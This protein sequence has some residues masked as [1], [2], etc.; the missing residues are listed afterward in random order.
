MK[1]HR[2]LVGDSI[3]MVDSGV[4]TFFSKFGINTASHITASDYIIDKGMSQLEDIM[5][6]A[7]EYAQFLKDTAQYWDIAIDF[8]ADGFLEESVVDEIHEDIVD[9]IGGDRSRL[10]RVYH[11]ER[12]DSRKWWKNICKDPRYNCLGIGSGNRRDREFY[13]HMTRFAHEHGKKVHALG[14]GAPSFLQSVPVDTVDTTSHLSGGKFGRVYTPI[15]LIGF[16]RDRSKDS[17]VYYD[18]L[19]TDS[20]AFLE[21]LW[22]DK[23]NISVE[24]LKSSPYVRN[25]LNI[26]H[27]NEYWDIPYT[28]K[29]EA[30]PL[31]DILGI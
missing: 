17:V 22:R 29:E 13:T 25:T 16:G 10:M 30:I 31:F 8:D 20:Q 23:Y 28:E 14:L 4:F 7:M 19:S 1:A 12:P 15:G 24:Q 6:Y 18:K 5:K 11:H 2:E 3:I 26:W 9:T 21:A 27:M